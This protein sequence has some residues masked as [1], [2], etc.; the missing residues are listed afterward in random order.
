LAVDF[1]GVGAP[2]F[3]ILKTSYTGVLIGVLI[4]GGSVITQ[5]ENI[6]RI[7]KVNL[8]SGLRV[9]LESKN[10]VI[11]RGMQESQTLVD[12]LGNFELKISE[13]GRIRMEAGRGHDDLVM[14]LALSLWLASTIKP[15]NMALE[16]K[17]RDMVKG[18][19]PT[20]FEDTGDAQ[21]FDD[22]GGW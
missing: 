22:G 14:S 4:T 19:T 5:D 21:F 3:D 1:T 8:I 2:V 17:I 18:C 6:Y 15:R 16:P 7:P 12:E 20:F 13:D 11:A 9:A 10:L